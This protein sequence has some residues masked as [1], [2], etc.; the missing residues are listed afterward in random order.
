MER[1]VASGDSWVDPLLSRLLSG[2]V[3]AAASCLF[4]LVLVVL[5]L[6][7]PISV[8]AMAA[9]NRAL[10]AVFSDDFNAFTAARSAEFGSTMLTAP[11]TGFAVACN[12]LLPIG[13]SSE[14]DD[15][16]GTNALSDG[17]LDTTRFGF[18]ADPCF[19]KA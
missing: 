3:V 1:F 5:S 9:I 12:L 7:P 13:D 6:S 10:T 11:L 19:K 15:I 14:E 17:T 16:D 2:D 8:M 4:S 18:S